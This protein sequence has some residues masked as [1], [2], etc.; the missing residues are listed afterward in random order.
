MLRAVARHLVR[1]ALQELEVFLACASLDSRM[2]RT[3]RLH[4]AKL[5]VSPFASFAV[6]R[7]FISCAA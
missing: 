6:I 4:S 2:S 7:S 5:T 3:M 1:Q